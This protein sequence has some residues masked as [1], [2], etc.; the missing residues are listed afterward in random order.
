MVTRLQS[1]GLQGAPLGLLCMLSA[2]LPS[3][4]Q[5]EAHRVG[6]CATTSWRR[7]PVHC[8]PPNTPPRELFVITVHQALPDFCS[9]F[10]NDLEK[11]V[12]KRPPLKAV[13]RNHTFPRPL[14]H[15]T[16]TMMPLSIY[17]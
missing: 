16:S 9:F 11:L 7:S 1:Y 8:F 17:S 13:I 4:P 15:H 6:H 5:H 3:E 10:R 2:T 14:T 12:K